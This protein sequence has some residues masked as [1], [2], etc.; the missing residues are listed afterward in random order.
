[1]IQYGVG[2]HDGRPRVVANVDGRVVD[3][4]RVPGVPAPLADALRAPT[5]NPFLALGREAWHLVHDKAIDAPEVTVGAMRLPFDVADYVDFY[6]FRDHAENLGRILRPGEAP[7]TPNWLHMPIGYHGRAGTVVVSGTPIRRPHGQLREGVV[8]PCARLDFEAEIGFVVG[9]PSAG[10]L[11][12]NDFREHVFGVVLVDDWSARDIQAWEYRP[13]GPFLGKSFAT[14]MSAWVTPLDQ[15]HWTTPPQRATPNYLADPDWPSAVDLTLEVRVNDTLV[16]T[17]DARPMHWTP[18]QQLAHL[19]SNG[20]GIR[21]G[22]L[23]ASGT[24]SSPGQPGSLIELTDNA[25]TPITLADGS[26]RGFLADGDTVTI[27]A[28]GVGDVVGQ[29]QGSVR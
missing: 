13:L 21:T 7:L 8:G 23:F 15:L 11:S 27:T 22:D 3:L 18:A 1:M 28:S 2:V 19:T 14:S 10:P 5:L 6:A 4:S 17:P 26:T 12:P 9:V 25:R 16:S 24:V 20:A 29:I